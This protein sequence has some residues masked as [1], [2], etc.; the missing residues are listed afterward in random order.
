MFG[1]LE[2]EE[3]V[4]EKIGLNLVDH[5]LNPVHTSCGN[6]RIPALSDHSPSN[7]GNF[8]AALRFLA[9]NTAE[10]LLPVL[11]LMFECYSDNVCVSRTR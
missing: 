6:R 2:V 5:G 3:V 1:K 9:M 7:P 4:R 11:F 8:P 10:P